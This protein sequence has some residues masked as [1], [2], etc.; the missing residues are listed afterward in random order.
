M[1]TNNIYSEPWCDLVFEKRNQAYGAYQ[2]RKV[3]NPN[4]FISFFG[5]LTLISGLILIP[6]LSDYFSKPGLRELPEE[7]AMVFIDP[8]ILLP[9][10]EIEEPEQLPK[11]QPQQ[12]RTIADTPPVIVDQSQE[13]NVHT[14]EEKASL[15]TSTSENQ[16]SETGAEK[17]KINAEIT[18]ETKSSFQE[19]PQPPILRKGYELT[20]QPKF[21]GGEKGMAEF[22][23]KNLKYPAMEK[24][25][26]IE[27][28]VYV[29]FVVSEQGKVMDVNVV[30]A[31]SKNFEKEA[32]RVVKIMPDWL[33]GKME[34]TNV[35][36][37]LVLP[38]RFELN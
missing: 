24:E 21:I 1:I 10:M 29:E 4:T 12:Q 17:G 20:E 9:K 31:P 19:Q 23:R 30:R 36:T 34:N 11:T 8:G 27:G 13:Q 3:T 14:T 22:L 38:I 37:K 5:S 35:P 16:G 18:V 26:G 2:I 33:P 6:K 7:E 32:S 28:L 25:N 15:A